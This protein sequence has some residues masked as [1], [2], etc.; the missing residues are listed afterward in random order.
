MACGRGLVAVFGAFVIG[1]AGCGSASPDDRVFPSDAE[2][3]GEALAVQPAVLTTAPDALRVGDGLPDGCG[4]G[5]KSSLAVVDPADGSVR[6]QMATPWSPDG[7]VV[8]GGDTVVVVGAIVD[9]FPPSVAGIA[10]G[11]GAVR[12]QRFL[13]GSRAELV[14]S[15]ATRVA[16]SLDD[17]LVVVGADGEITDEIPSRLRR[18]HSDFGPKAYLPALATR[19][20]GGVMDPF[21]D[22][23]T[24][25]DLGHAVFSG[26]PGVAGD[27][28]VFVVASLVG[29]VETAP[30][31]SWVNTSIPL[32]DEFSQIVEVSVGDDEVLVL[33]GSELGPNRRLVVL[34]RADGSERW[35]LDGVRS[36]AAAGDQIVYDVRNSTADGY[37]PT[38]DV[39]VVSDQDPAQALWS[40][41]STGRL[42]GYVGSTDTAHVFLTQRPAIWPS[43]PYPETGPPPEPKVFD[44]ELVEVPIDGGTTPVVLTASTGDRIDPAKAI[45]EEGWFA[46]I[47][48]GGVVLRTI[49]G[50]GSVMAR[51]EDALVLV[52]AN[53]LLIVGSGRDDFSCD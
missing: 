46:A 6:W 28:A 19:A 37:G 26:E 34:E 10:L 20:A 17:R 40:V 14:A 9:E 8:I 53:G 13:D 24:Q 31:R 1:V 35:V 51:T 44:P 12:W 25:G 41:P 21:E 48:P 2:L 11:S 7:P 47:G 43:P 32:D 30:A 29:F 42:G 27:V 33:I 23:V 52:D 22:S 50:H 15:D 36:A 16:V 45:I 18:A 3:L 49:D 4:T 39:F 5:F 38:R